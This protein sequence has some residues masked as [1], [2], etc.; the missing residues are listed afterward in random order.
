MKVLLLGGTG[1]FG[2]SAATLLAGESLITELGLASRHPETAQR[3]MTEIGDKAHVVCV[4]I[5]DVPRLA[6]IAV[7]YDLIINAAGPTSEVQIPAIQAAIEAGVNYCDLAAIGTYAE[8]ALQLDLPARARGITAIFGTG[9]IAVMNLLAVHAF[10]QLDGVEQISVCM[11]FDYTSGDFFSP[12]QSL[13]RARDLGRVETSWDLY[14]PPA[15]HGAFLTEEP[16]N[17]ARRDRILRGSNG[18]F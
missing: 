10:H 9:W 6:S 7:D 16:A 4:D 17:H 11:L 15:A 13:A 2:K 8:S 1:V 14:E 3:A 12:E 18:F 5:R